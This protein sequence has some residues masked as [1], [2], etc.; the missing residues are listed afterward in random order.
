MPGNKKSGKSQQNMA[1]ASSIIYRGP[2]IS[3]QEVLQQEMFETVSHEDV[4][5]TTTGTSAITQAIPVSNPSSSTSWSSLA[6][7]YDEF[8]V[9]ASSCQWVPITSAA[10]ATTIGGVLLGAVDRDSAVVPTTY[11]ALPYYDSCRYTPIDRP[12]KFEWK[13]TGT[14]EAVWLN[15]SSPATTGAFK[16]FCQCAAFASTVAGHFHVVYRIQFRGRGN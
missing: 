15:T 8:R 16:F 12:I 2:V 4:T 13:M 1:S 14:D 9:I 10:L 3:R 6:A 11:A 7:L 5:V